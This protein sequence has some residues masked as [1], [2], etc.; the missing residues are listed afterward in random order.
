MWNVSGVAGAAPVW[1]EMMNYLHRNDTGKKE[2]PLP[3]LVRREVE[4][5]EGITASREEWFIPGTEPH[6]KNQKTGQFNHRILYPPSGTVIALDP[7][8]PVEYQKIFFVAQTSEND[9]R[10]I[11]NDTPI[12]TKGKTIPWIPKAGKY[13]LALADRNE[14]ILDYI[15]FEVRSQGID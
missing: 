4:F 15:H 2:E 6:S 9:F 8:I 5:P 10:W 3:R 1:I 7:D 12:E 11:L 13:S 14:K